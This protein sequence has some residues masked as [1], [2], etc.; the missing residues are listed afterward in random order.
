MKEKRNL[1]MCV[2]VS[3]ARIEQQLVQG[4]TWA[5]G[6]VDKLY[7][8]A[9]LTLTDDEMHHIISE[10]CTYLDLTGAQVREIDCKKYYYL[11]TRGKTVNE[12]GEE[13]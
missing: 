13:F 1:S 12:D 4:G 6:D 7:I 5:I 3:A 11:P 2:L 9:E 10:I 8:P